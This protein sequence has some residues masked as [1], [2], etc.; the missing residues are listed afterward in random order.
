METKEALYEKLLK[1]INNSALFAATN[2][3]VITEVGE[4]FA[5]GYMEDTGR[6]RN[7]HG[8]HHGGALAT[9]IDTLCGVAAFS[10]GKNPLTVHGTIEYLRV[11]KGEIQGKA[12]VRKMGSTICV[13]QA[14]LWNKAGEEVAI[15]TFSFCFVGDVN[16]E[17]K[18]SE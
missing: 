2:G 3:I 12:T 15:G 10:M 14:S 6:T 7:H 4:G 8:S 9:M 18:E 13:C 5:T 17:E 16:M 1:E 11:A